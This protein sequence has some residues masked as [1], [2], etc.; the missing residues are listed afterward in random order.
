MYNAFVTIIAFL[1]MIVIKPVFAADSELKDYKFSSRVQF[2]ACLDSEDKLKV[3]RKM[4]DEHIAEYNATISLIQTGAASLV[5]EQKNIDLADAMQVDAFNKRSEKHNTLVKS[6]NDRAGKLKAEGDAYNAE[7]IK[8]NERCAGLVVRIADRE[9][10]LKERNA[11]G[12][13]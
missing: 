3:L 4:L 1:L 5:D 2:R 8:Y 6:S 7:S 12:K 13:R 10:V 11:D 9:A